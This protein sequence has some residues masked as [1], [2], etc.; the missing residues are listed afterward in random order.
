MPDNRGPEWGDFADPDEIAAH[1]QA[2]NPDVDTG[3]HRFKALEYARQGKWMPAL[4][5]AKLAG[6]H[7]RTWTHLAGQFDM[8]D[9]VAHKVLDELTTGGHGSDA[10]TEFVD[11]YAHSYLPFGAENP[12][13]RD[14]ELLNRLHEIATKNGLIHATDCIDS[15]PNFKDKHKDIR[16]VSEFWR[17]FESDVRPDHFA[18]VQAHHTGQHVKLTDHRGN[19]GSSEDHAHILPHM[20]TYAKLCQDKVL[21]TGITDLE[22]PVH[23]G[24]TEA[25]GDVFIKHIRGKPHVLVYRGVGGN[26]AEKLRNAAKLNEDTDTVE[27]K[28]LTVPM[29]PMSSWSTNHRVAVMFAKSRGKIKGQAECQGLVIKKWMPVADIVH[30]GFHSVIPQQQHA[31][32]DEHE[33]VFR[34]PTG[35]LKISTSDFHLHETEETKDY[36]AGDVET[37]QVFKPTKA[38]KAKPQPKESAYSVE[39]SKAKMAEQAQNRENDP[40]AAFKAQL[41]TPVAKSEPE[42]YEEHEIVDLSEDDVWA[43]EFGYGRQP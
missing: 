26:Y 24:K 4:A 11:A 29:A 28:T 37:H 27:K 23:K 6:G 15:H 10:L 18:A 36:G 9:D 12:K 14:S 25:D 32:P 30:S 5:H 42:P 33:L 34:H 21:S 7:R 1:Y 31:H 39:D 17:G 22:H 43:S 41:K 3:T 8:P 2:A 38:V 35:Q 40:L 19:T 13:K 16:P 20:A